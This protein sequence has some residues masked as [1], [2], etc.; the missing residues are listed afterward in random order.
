[1]SFSCVQTLNEG[2]NNSSDSGGQNIVSGNL[3]THD[4]NQAIST[5]IDLRNLESTTRDKSD[6]ATTTSK[7][8]NRKEA[9][10][11]SQVDHIAPL[12]TGADISDSLKFD[13]TKFSI[14]RDSEEINFS[15]E[16]LVEEIEVESVLDLKL[17]E[18]QDIDNSSAHKGKK[19]TN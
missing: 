17:D 14:L 10:A 3:S 15:G 16:K 6:N 18:E 13:D 9:N 2:G 11:E 12:R 4:T 8:L 7:L 1:M 19:F 5:E